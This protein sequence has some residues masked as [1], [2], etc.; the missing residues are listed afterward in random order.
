MSNQTAVA[1]ATN[2]P[3]RAPSTIRVTLHL[4]ESLVARYERQGADAGLALEELLTQR[5]NRCVVHSASRPL[6]FT[7]KE[8]TELEQITGG[9]VLETAAAA[10]AR[11]RTAVSV[12]VGDVAVTLNERLLSRLRTR[13]F[14]NET[15]E[16][17]VKRE[18]TRGLESFCGMR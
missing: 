17:V 11:L 5:L 15:F 14:R 1:V 4:D 2:T 8:R 12:K 10:L 7:D 9:H 6:Y 16:G 18:V 3:A 13:V